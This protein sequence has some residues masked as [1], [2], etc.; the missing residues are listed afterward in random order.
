M[1]SDDV[2]DANNTSAVLSPGSSNGREPSWII[3]SKES[4]LVRWSKGLVLSILA[5]S[6]ATCVVMTYRIT[7][8]G[9]Q[10]EFELKVSTSWNFSADHL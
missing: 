3:A 1:N 9:E 6:A 5:A 10:R 7:K 8:A 4:N 2:K